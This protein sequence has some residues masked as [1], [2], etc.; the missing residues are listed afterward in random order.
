M[1]IETAAINKF[2]PFYVSAI[3]KATMTT[4]E[5]AALGR[6]LTAEEVEEAAEEVA[7]GTYKFMRGYKTALKEN[8]GTISNEEYND[9]YQLIF[10]EVFN[11]AWA[12][13]QRATEEMRERNNKNA[14]DNVSY[15][16]PRI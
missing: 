10:D 15:M 9:L 12:L 3:V 2:L 5:A 6:E 11:N 14:R 16:R 1:K 4:C 13:I 7:N 8:G